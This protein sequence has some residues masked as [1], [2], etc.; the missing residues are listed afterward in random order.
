MEAPKTA[1]VEMMFAKSPAK[2]TG[3]RSAGASPEA[4]EST[5]LTGA[6]KVRFA[7]GGQAHGEK[8]GKTK[9]C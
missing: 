3:T 9:G 4:A 6:M 5:P 2:T 8:R 7:D 1:I